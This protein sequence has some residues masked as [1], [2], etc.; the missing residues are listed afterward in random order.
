MHGRPVRHRGA[1]MGGPRRATG[2]SMIEMLVVVVMIAAVGVLSVGVLGGGMDRIRLN[3][4]AKELA[5]QLRFARA[6]AIA[7]GT[8]QRFLL[9]PRR[10]AWEGAR[11]RKGTLHESLEVSFTGARE[12]QP[13]EDVGAIVF[14]GDGAST[15]GRIRVGLRG[16]GWNVDVAWLTGEVR[17]H[18]ANAP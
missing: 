12:V 13:A 15:G 14:F 4:A 5:G 7:T 8:P 3:S 10:H 18:R 17:L 11:G 1:A 2:F 16:A 9:D 6:Q